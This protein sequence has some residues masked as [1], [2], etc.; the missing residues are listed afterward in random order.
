MSAEWII[1]VAGLITALV[2]AYAAYSKNKLELEKMRQ[3]LGVVSHELKPNSGRSTRDVV[4]RI[5]K[6]VIAIQDEQKFLR[7][8][9]IRLAQVDVEDRSRAKDDHKQMWETIN[10]IRN[11]RR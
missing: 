10:R 7:S 9:Q 8:E 5:E 4:N 6:A 3:E 11:G 1:A 2:G